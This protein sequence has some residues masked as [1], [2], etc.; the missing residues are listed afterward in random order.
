MN[1]L[2]DALNKEYW[3]KCSECD[4]IY[5]DKEEKLAFPDS[6]NNN[7]CCDECFEAFKNMPCNIKAE[8]EHKW[9]LEHKDD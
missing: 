2:D 7:G 5:Y 8:A 1:K 9:W 6:D 4:K 3:Y